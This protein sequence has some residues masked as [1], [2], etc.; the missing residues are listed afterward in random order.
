MYFFV[1]IE[2]SIVNDEDNVELT[3]T[4]NLDAL[5]HQVLCPSIFGIPQLIRILDALYASL[6]AVRDHTL[7]CL[8]ITL[9]LLGHAQI[10]LNYNI[11]SND[12][13]IE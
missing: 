2:P 9:S 6:L 3:L 8:L 4:A 11:W 5:L 10:K 7:F 1:P 12:R 13:I